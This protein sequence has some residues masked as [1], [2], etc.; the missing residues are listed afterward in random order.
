MKWQKKTLNANGVSAWS[1]IAS[2]VC[3]AMALVGCSSSSGPEK[4]D[5]SCEVSSEEEVLTERFYSEGEFSLEEYQTICKS[6]P[7]L[8]DVDFRVTCEANEQKGSYHKVD[9]VASYDVAD[10]EKTS[11]DEI[12]TALENSCKDLM[13]SYGDR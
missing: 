4:E 6:M 11:L 9:V 13:K 7:E 2:L 8:S 3:G 12:R 1:I 10:L 5:N